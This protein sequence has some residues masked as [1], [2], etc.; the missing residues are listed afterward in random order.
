[1]A[2]QYLICYMPALFVWGLCDIYRRFFNCFYHT[3]T[4][5]TCFMIALVAHPF[6]AH[7]L[8]VHHS[9]GLQGVAAASL[10]SNGICYTL[11]RV[12]LARQADM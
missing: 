4:P 6:I 11:L 12:R 3:K 10:L 1:M 9:M 5:M 7:F 8:V 2:R